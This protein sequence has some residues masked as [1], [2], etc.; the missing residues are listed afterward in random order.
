[1]RD[2]NGTLNIL[3]IAYVVRNNNVKFDY[4]IDV[5][6]NYL[7]ETDCFEKVCCNIGQEEKKCVYS[8][9]SFSSRRLSTVFNNTC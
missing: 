2:Q 1:M 4:L 6:F 8:H 5:K 9:I 3:L 7:I